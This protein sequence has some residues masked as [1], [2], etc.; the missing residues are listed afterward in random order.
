MEKISTE[1]IAFVIVMAVLLMIVM[2]I[3]Q[4]R[5]GK[6]LSELLFGASRKKKPDGAEKPSKKGGGREPR[7]NNGTKND[8]TVF[9]AQL[10][11]FA[12][13]N[14][15][16]VVAPGSVEYQGK[17]AQLIA[18][19]VAPSGVTGIYCLGFGGVVSPG[20]KDGP[21]KQHMNGQDLTFRNPLTVCKEQYEL[22]KAAM[23]EAGVKGNLDIVT[24]FT[25]P[26]VTLKATPSALIYTQKQFMEHLKNT[27]SLKRGDIDVK[28]MTGVLAR[29]AK[30]KEK[31]AGRNKK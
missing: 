7:M 25:N 5:T 23:D 14:G 28:E 17:T 8:L 6:S 24:V 29:L 30:I 31:K 11:K 18:F 9:V 19:L 21:W 1:Q 16:G 12:N 3:V 26:R 13:K 15:M 10:L 4:S 20:E 22:V 27:D 2:P